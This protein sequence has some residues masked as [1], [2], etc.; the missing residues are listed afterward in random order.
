MGD[1][2]SRGLRA[3]APHRHR[4]GTT[5]APHRHRTG[6]TPAPHRHHTGTAPAPHRHHTGT[7]PAPHRHHT[8]TTPAPHRH[9]TG[10]TPAP[11]RHPTGTARTALKWK[12]AR[13]R[14]GVLQALL[15]RLSP[16]SRLLCFAF[17]AARENP[18]TR[19]SFPVRVSD[20]L[21]AQRFSFSFSHVLHEPRDPSPVS[22]RNN[23]EVV[24]SFCTP[25]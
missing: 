17:G 20:S 10:T 6:T 12:E 14:N 7:T 4:T 19:N 18:P 1:G 25:H 15:S 23:L 22:D 16:I 5:P 8:G 2:V 11:Y 21:S 3:P 13:N 24:D 9:H